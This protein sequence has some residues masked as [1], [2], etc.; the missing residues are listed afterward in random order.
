MFTVGSA[1]SRDV[2]REV[3]FVRLVRELPSNREWANVLDGK[4]A[5][6][7]R[8]G[9]RRLEDA[10]RD[11][12]LVTRLEGNRRSRA[13]VQLLERGLVQEVVGDAEMGLPRLDEFVRCLNR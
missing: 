13:T 1:V 10:G 3:N 5:R 6:R 11:H 7:A 2:V 4:L 8:A 9:F 12:D